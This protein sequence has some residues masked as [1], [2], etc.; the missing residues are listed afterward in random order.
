MHVTTSRSKNTESFYITK[1]YFSDQGKST[2]KI[3]RKLG[4]LSE[5]SEKL[6]TDRDGVMA[7]AKEQARLETEKCKEENVRKTVVIPFRVDRQMDYNGRKLY[8]GGYLFPQS[9]YYR[10]KMDCICRKIKKKY[11][12]EWKLN[13]ILSDLIYARIVA[14][15]SKTSSYQTVSRFLEPPAYELEDIYRIIPILARE[16]DNIQQEVY[17]TSLHMGER[18]IRMLHYGRS[19]YIFQKEN[20]NGNMHEEYRSESGFTLHRVLMEE[21]DSGFEFSVGMFRDDDGIPLAFSV[22]RGDTEEKITSNSLERK[23]IRDIGSERIICGGKMTEAA[24]FKKADGMEEEAFKIIKAD[25]IKASETVPWED[26][27]KA[28]FLVCFLA[29][30]ICS[31]LEKQLNYE[32]TYDEIVEALQGMNFASIEEQGYMPLYTRT[33]ITDALHDACG[34]RTDYQFINKS[35]MREIQKKSKGRT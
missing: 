16:S 26:C 8:E 27:V 22:C 10:L 13:A 7:W 21:T 25:Y 32:Y 6:G 34:F 1:S 17:K 4:T 29:Q 12:C 30:L 24:D 31:L 11:A 33:K 14:P 23:I 2:S 3:I 5:L 20:Q 19:E 28:H 15:F 9:I 35:K 18:N